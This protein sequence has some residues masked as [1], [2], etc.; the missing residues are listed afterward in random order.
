[1]RVVYSKSQPGVT[2][3]SSHKWATSYNKLP[4]IINKVFAILIDGKMQL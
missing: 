3:R 2:K 4:L 1:M